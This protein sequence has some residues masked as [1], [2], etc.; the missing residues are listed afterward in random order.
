MSE[1]P[2]IDPKI[3]LFFTNISKQIRSRVKLVVTLFL[4]GLIAG[5]PLSKQV[6]DWLLNS[7]L[8]PDEVNIIVL[9]PVEFIMIQVK[10]GAWLG[11]SLAALALL[12]EGAWRSELARKIPRPSTA[13]FM[14][15][16][17]IFALAVCGLLY[18]W[19]LLTPMLLDYLAADAQSA[20]LSTEWK[21]SSFVGFIINLMI[22]CVIG[23]QAPLATILLL[24]S[25]A[26]GRETLTAYRKHIWFATFVLG[27]AF[28][29][30]D[31]LSLFLVSVPIIALFEIALILETLM[32]G[33]SDADA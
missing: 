16:A 24:R 21:L 9:T 8:A 1:E 27:A 18:S 33:N 11:F 4:A 26:V 13:V 5:I 7:G 23:F 14:S 31:P 10:V 6:V 19:E 28:S 25:G 3:K 15:L 32:D 29:P 2:L 22:A 12:I 30:P 17:S 20:G